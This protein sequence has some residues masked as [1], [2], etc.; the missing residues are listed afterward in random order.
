MKRDW[1]LVRK[2]LLAAESTDPG[3]S[4]GHRDVGTDVDERVFEF[5]AKIMN[6]AGL[7]GKPYSGGFV[8]S[9]LSWHGHDIVDHFRDEDAFEAALKR[10]DDAGLG[11]CEELLCRVISDELRKKRKAH[12]GDEEWTDLTPMQFERGDQPKQLIRKPRPQ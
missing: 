6:D 7:W 9:G 4:F 12:D 2:M 1:R 3:N 11:Q 5:H 10:I 8:G